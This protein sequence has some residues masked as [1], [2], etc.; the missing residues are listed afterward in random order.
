MSLLTV[1]SILTVLAIA[2]VLNGAAFLILTKG[3]R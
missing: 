1:E 3:I 2:L